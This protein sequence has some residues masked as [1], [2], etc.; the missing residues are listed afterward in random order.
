MRVLVVASLY[1]N[2]AS[3]RRGLFIR[4]RVVHAAR[5]GLDV[6]VVAPVPRAAGA[7]DVGTIPE[8]E[9]RDGLPVAHPRYLVIP[10]IGAPVHGWTYLAALRRQMSADDEPPPDVVDAHYLYPDGYAA[11]SF[12]RRRGVPVVVSARGT[13][14]NVIARDP[15]LG[16][17]VR[18]TIRR[19]TR[20]VAVSEDLAGKLLRL[21]AP[22]SRLRTIPNGVDAERFRIGDRGAARRRLGVPEGV[23]LLLTVGNLVRN[24]GHHR[25]IRALATGGAPLATACLWIAGEGPERAALEREIEERGLARRVR[26]LGPIHPEALPEYYAAADLF[27]LAT[28]REGWPNAVMEALACGLPV[29]ATRTGGVPELV[30]E[31]RD[32]LLVDDPSR[33]LAR[34]IVDAFGRAWD[35]NAISQRTRKRTWDDVAGEVVS[36][37]R[38]ALDEDARSPSMESAAR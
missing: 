37:L 31:G 22:P 20:V 6:R 21:G 5:R 16:H 36:V 9:V 17:F 13:D 28:E 32:G 35:R 19:A 38:E 27:C 11:V 14:V 30:T 4:E 7:P 18:E 1:P 29:V 3:P 12:A 24:K 2:P 26:L 34:T 33:G 15:I 10:G 8:R 23:P 25:L